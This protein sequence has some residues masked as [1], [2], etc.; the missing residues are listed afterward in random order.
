MGSLTEA[1]ALPGTTPTINAIAVSIGG[2]FRTAMTVSERN[3]HRKLAPL[4]GAM[5]Y[6]LRFP[7]LFLE[8]RLSGAGLASLG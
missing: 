6:P 1:F 3:G 7:F 2:P 5:I 8:E 4:R